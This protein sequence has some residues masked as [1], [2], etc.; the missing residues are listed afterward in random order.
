MLDKDYDFV[1]SK[2]TDT[3]SLFMFRVPT[4]RVQYIEGI[5][6]RD[7]AVIDAEVVPE[8]GAC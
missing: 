6:F 8:Q 2:F 7:S 3:S 4:D 1:I 5:K